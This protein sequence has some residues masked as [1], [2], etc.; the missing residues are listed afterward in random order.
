MP[1]GVYKRKRSVEIGQRI[2]FLVIKELLDKRNC[3]CLC[4]CGNA[5]VRRDSRLNSSETISC[6]CMVGKAK[7]H[8]MSYASEYRIW[9]GIKSRCR[10]EKS[11]DYQNY[12][13]R[14]ILM[15]DSWFDNFMSFYNDVGPR[16]SMSH[17]IGRIDNNGNYEKSN[18]EWQIAKVQCR[19][20][21]SNKFITYNDKTLTIAEWSEITGI[22]YETLCGRLSRG[23]SVERALTDPVKH[24]KKKENK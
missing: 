6:G 1:S 9:L 18:V 10:D 19:N 24:K 8:G 5:C 16:P 12:G 13:K 3:L 17:S 22:N 2:G 21:N 7:T 11:K 20:R 15:C 14:G 4:D 23:Y